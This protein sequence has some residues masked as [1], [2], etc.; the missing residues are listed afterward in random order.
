M[1]SKLIHHHFY[2]NVGVREDFDFRP[3]HKPD[4]P[5][6]RNDGN[7]SKTTE[8]K[9]EYASPVAAFLLSAWQQTFS[10]FS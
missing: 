9:I 6:D 3:I 5:L 1:N 4:G 8:S 10:I 7:D 2:C